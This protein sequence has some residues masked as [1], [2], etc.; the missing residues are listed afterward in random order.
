MVLLGQG[1]GVLQITRRLVQ[2]DRVE[3]VGVE[4]VVYATHLTLLPAQPI[5]VVVAVAV[6]VANLQVVRVRQAGRVLLLLDT[7]EPHQ[8]QADQYLAVEDTHITRST[9]QERLR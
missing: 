2:L 8:Q 7:P 1:A 9:L 3:Q 5:L 6:R 4:Q